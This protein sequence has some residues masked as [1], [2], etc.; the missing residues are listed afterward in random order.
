M[1][2]ADLPPPG[3]P[4]LPDWYIPRPFEEQLAARYLK[5]AHPVLLW[6]PR[7]QGRT[8]LQSHIAR[9][10]RDA[11]PTKRHVIKIDFRTF[12]PKSLET[13]DTC[14]RALAD[15]IAES[16][17]DT[18]SPSS[19]LAPTWEGRGDA[20]KKINEWLARTVL[21]SLPGLLL[22]V[23]EHADVVH[24][25]GYYEDFASLLRSWA[26]KAQIGEPWSRLRLLIS[27]PTHPARLPTAKYA[28]WFAGL[29]DPI[30]VPDLART[31]V[32]ELVARHGLSW[33]PAE[34]D[35]LFDLVG[36]QPYLV[37]AVLVDVLDGHY[38][39][40]RLAA[41][42][43]LGPS[44]V[45]RHLREHRTRL[46]ASPELAAAFAALAASPD[47]VVKAELIDA[48]VRQG[49]V[50]E[51]SQGT[52]PVRYRLYER[53]LHPD[54]EAKPAHRKSRLFYSY[55]RAD[56]A[57]RERL[58]VHLAVLR[59]QGLIESWC[60]RCISP[61]A[62]TTLDV[63]RHLEEA[64]IVLLLVTADF[65]AHC[66]DRVMQRALE[67]HDAGQ[68][69]VVPII[70]RPC[71]WTSAPFAALSAAP[72]DAIPVSRWSDPEEAW[73]DIAQGIRRLIAD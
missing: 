64:D 29:S 70:L 1:N 52:H 67:R 46:D 19:A 57:L 66:W 21:K 16:L 4:Y 24:T 53:L 42:D 41:G 22:L 61:G 58:Q 27:V 26:E 50:R 32:T 13:I 63:D 36:G 6:G 23:L 2:P 48:L 38:T 69:V 33:T 60:D 20:R 5:F 62:E 68:A 54:P 43:F 15:T 3:T 18:S 56:E 37:R 30:L 71:D 34:V 39:L 25:Q 73:V 49:L 40:D 55:A 44:L 47:A 28:S 51:G 59:H 14:L 12:P 9:T 8:W 72:R 7:H 17:D 10:W 65:L 35:R 45:A 31:Q 11:D